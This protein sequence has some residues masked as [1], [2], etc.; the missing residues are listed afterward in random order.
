LIVI[1]I[2]VLLILFSAIR[3]FLPSDDPNAEGKPPCQ[4][5]NI[6]QMQM[7]QKIDGMIE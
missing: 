4:G 6:G 1:I 7:G 2:L 5:G 3:I